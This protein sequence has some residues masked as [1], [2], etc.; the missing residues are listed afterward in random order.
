MS[1]QRAKMRAV[2]TILIVVLL[3]TLVFAPIASAGYP[4]SV[5]NWPMLMTMVQ[6]QV[7][8]IITNYI[9]SIWQKEVAL[10]LQP[11][12]INGGALQGIF[13]QHEYSTMID[14]YGRRFGATMGSFARDAVSGKQTWEGA[15]KNVNSQTIPTFTFANAYSNPS[16]YM[17]SAQ[18]ISTVIAG[19]PAAANM[20]KMSNDDIGALQ[21]GDLHRQMSA[22]SFQQASEAVIIAENYKKQL[23]SFNP[24]SFDGK[25]PEQAIKDVAKLLYFN[26][27]LQAETLKVQGQAEQRHAFSR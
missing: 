5:V 12:L 17:N 2:G 6:S 15:I 13:N 14:T 23:A 11:G 20:E 1:L 19:P 7:T 25:Y 3:S 27:M 24:S 21:R 9:N 22:K 18:T 16:A 26:A 8:T 10:K 4:V